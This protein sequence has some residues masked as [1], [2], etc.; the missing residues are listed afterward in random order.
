M[1]PDPLDALRA[2]A[3]E[4]SDRRGPR[5]AATVLGAL[6][7]AVLVVGFQRS[8]AEPEPARDAPIE[9]STPVDPAAAMPVALPTTTTTLS[10]APVGCGPVGGVDVDGDGCRE[11]V[12]VDG[13]TIEVGQ[14]TFVVGVAGDEVAVR[15][16]DCDGESTPAV[17]R[18]ATGEVFVFARW[19]PVADVVVEPVAT[20][21][22]GTELVVA[23]SSEPC[24]GLGVRSGGTVV[25]I[26]RSRS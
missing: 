6:G 20:V 25:E 11:P 13:R 12:E 5:P 8:G 18:P 22:G 1:A 2:S 7:V 19:D 4:P 26:V 23:P 24:S 10:I 21:A 14:V 15:D 9:T 3:T 16:W 17:L